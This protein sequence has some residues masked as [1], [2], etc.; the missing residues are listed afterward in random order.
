MSKSR[1]PGA[2]LN[3]RTAFKEATGDVWSARMHWQ[4]ARGRGWTVLFADCSRTWALSHD[5][6]IRP[7]RRE[8]GAPLSPAYWIRWRGRSLRAWRVDLAREPARFE[9]PTGVRLR[10]V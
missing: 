6:T 7:D 4:W 9:T 10:V 8:F 2:D 3:F 5:D 1:F